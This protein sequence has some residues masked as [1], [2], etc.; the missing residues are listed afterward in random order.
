MNLVNFCNYFWSKLEPATIEYLLE[1]PQLCGSK[2]STGHKRVSQNKSCPNSFKSLTHRANLQLVQ[3]YKS[4]RIGIS[5]KNLQLF[6]HIISKK[7]AACRAIV[8]AKVNVSS[9]TTH[10]S[11][12]INI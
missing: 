6:D 4:T 11:M 10:H 1:L 8:Y 3:D 2:N 12:L 5:F 7:L 9:S